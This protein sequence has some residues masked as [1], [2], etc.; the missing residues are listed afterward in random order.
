[1]SSS[2]KNKD[3]IDTVTDF[4]ELAKKGS[5]S[6]DKTFFIQQVIDN[7]QKS[8]L[9]TYPKG[10]GKTLNLKML[11]VFFELE[12]EDCRQEKSVTMDN[13]WFSNFFWFWKKSDLEI[14]D[15]N[16]TCNKD[17]F[18]PLFIYSVNSG[19]YMKYQ[20][21]YPVI[22]VNLKNV[23]GNS[24]V[25]VKE[26]LKDLIKSLYEKHSYL[27]DSDKLRDDQKLDFKKYVYKD[28]S[29]N[30]HS[31]A[32]KESLTFLSKLLFMHYGKKVYMLV[33]DYDAPVK[34]LFLNYIGNKI[35]FKDKIIDEVGYLISSVVCA[36]VRNNEHIEKVI[37]TGTFDPTVIEYEMGCNSIM[38]Y[39]ISDEYFSKSFGF[40]DEEI[41]KLVAQLSPIN[42]EKTINF[43][44]N[45]YGGYIVPA[46]SQVRKS[47]P[48]ATIYYLKSIRENKE[49]FEFGQGYTLLQTLLASEANKNNNFSEK[50]DGI[51]QHGSVQM[52]FKNY[53]SLFDYDWWSE[54]DNE[55]FFSYL[56][57]NTGLLTAQKINS[58][59]KFSIPNKSS[60]Q[61]FLFAL[62]GS[63]YEKIAYKLQT[64]Y[65]LEIFKLIEKKD[66]EGAIEKLQEEKIVCEEN[67]MN[68][69]FFHLVVAFGLKNVFTELLGAEC[70]GNLYFANDKIEHLK[71]VDYAFL[72]KNS[73]ILHEM[74]KY[75][76]NNNQESINIS[77]LK[78]TIFCYIFAK[79]LTTTSVTYGVSNNIANNDNTEKNYH[80]K[81]IVDIFKQMTQLYD[82]SAVK[83]Q[84][85]QHS[86]YEKINISNPST[87]NS[88]KQFEK[89]LLHN[90][91]AQVVMNEDCSDKQ[92][93]LSELTYPI[94]SSFLHSGT[95]LKFTLCN[96]HI[97]D[98]L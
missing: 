44:K 40:S 16:I 9:I 76:Q 24:I 42:S 83:N 26:R 7:S 5:L 63:K 30:F 3:N 39:S 2:K 10:W 81:L 17:I 55:L 95:E 85:T 66:E 75:H 31:Y 53:V 37:L 65:Q 58:Q 80:I 97:K 45:V 78:D 69:N 1:M 22:Y 47:I 86:D 77:E 41:N 11:K 25:T 71:P 34:F 96:D 38:T 35:L 20:G 59:Y 23:I 36:T 72:F 54:I 51:A 6:V 67:A 92:K 50:L 84:C 70:A 14:I 28:Y 52:D 93:K 61:E 43:I 48:A 12:N 57:L 33:D 32:L 56:L 82:E 8:I 98:E 13:S 62:K 18:K 90:E 19:H 4:K 91:N 27:A 49:Y 89:Y 79:N 64:F 46:D 15:K 88:L 21:S 94:F 60:L 87:F 68:F 73:N 74:K 29:V